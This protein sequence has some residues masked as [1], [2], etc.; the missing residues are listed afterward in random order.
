MFGLSGS[1]SER[2]E[3]TR[4]WHSMELCGGNIRVGLFAL[5]PPANQKRG[6][7][8]LERTEQVTVQYLLLVRTFHQSSGNEPKCLSLELTQN[9]AVGT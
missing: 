7:Q 8:A 2:F 5:R 1:E 9:R 3:A 6:Q 4:A